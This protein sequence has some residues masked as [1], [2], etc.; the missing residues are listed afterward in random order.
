VVQRGE[1]LYDLVQALVGYRP[2]ECVLVLYLDVKA[3]LICFDVLSEGAPESVEFNI[4]R[5]LKTAI[6]RGA[7]G[8]IVAH[9]HPS[10][11]A[12]PSRGDIAATRSLVAAARYLEIV[13]HDH[14][15]AAKGAISSI[16]H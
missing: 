14:V 8:M 4:R 7:S 11:D 15:I 16:L 5:I 2:I 3:A 12:Q 9:N 6:D 13:V 10:G 1:A